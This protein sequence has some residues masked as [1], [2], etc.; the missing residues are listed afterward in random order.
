M[1]PVLEVQDSP[2]QYILGAEDAYFEPNMEYENSWV[3]K[4]GWKVAPHHTRAPNAF[5]LERVGRAWDH[6]AVGV[7]LR[8]RHF[9]CACRSFI[10]P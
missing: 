5:Y 3:P 8:D 10:S 9:L 1:P 2:G 7:V 4:D 6:L